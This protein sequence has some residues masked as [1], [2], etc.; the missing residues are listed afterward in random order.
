MT[1]YS[2]DIL[3]DDNWESLALFAH[4]CDFNAIID[5]CNSQFDCGNNLYTPAD[6]IR[7]M[8]MDTG[9]I[10]WQWSDDHPEWDDEPSNIDDDCGFDP[11]LGCFTDDC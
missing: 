4:N 6:D 2:V 9:K 3:N 1:K 5:F 8:D 11:Y 7:I 10:V